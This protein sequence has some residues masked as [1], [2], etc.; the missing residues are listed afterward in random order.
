MNDGPTPHGI[1]A[2]REI[3]ASLVTQSATIAYVERDL[4]G[5]QRQLK[6]ARERYEQTAAKRDAQIKELGYHATYVSDG[7]A[8][9]LLEEMARQ[10]EAELDRLRNPGEPAQ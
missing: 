8:L 4:A 7:R 2:L 9:W 6:D 3:L 10:Y 1:K 5:K